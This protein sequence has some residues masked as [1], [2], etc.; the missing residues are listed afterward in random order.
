M[1]ITDSGGLQKEAY[2]FNKFCLTARDQTE[3]TEL[4][5]VGANKLVGA[6]YDLIVAGW[7]EFK[8]TN[9]SGNT[10]LYGNGKA[11]ENIVKALLNS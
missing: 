6:N 1:V 7:E 2:F 3:W 8:T 11:C 4:V 10:A 9:F 5:E